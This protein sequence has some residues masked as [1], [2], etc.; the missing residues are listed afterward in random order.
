MCT[1]TFHFSLFCERLAGRFSGTAILEPGGAAAPRSRLASADFTVE[2]Q[3]QSFLPATQV[4]LD[5]EPLDD[6]PN[7]RRLA[8]SVYSQHG[9]A[10]LHSA[11]RL[12]AQDA[13]A[14]VSALQ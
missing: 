13:Q 8:L 10:I 7:K 2:S 6:S 12:S 9:R 4:A 14:L 5:V 11:S 3:D 1:L